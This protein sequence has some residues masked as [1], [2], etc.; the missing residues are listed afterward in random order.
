MSIKR[1]ASLFFRSYSDNLP[2]MLITE[3][4]IAILPGVSHLI[5]VSNPNY[6]KTKS[7]KKLDQVSASDS[8]PVLTRREREEIEA[9]RLAEEAEAAL[10]KQEMETLAVV[11]QVRQFVRRSKDQADADKIIS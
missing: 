9:Q 5:A 1:H 3:S 10:I 4:Q 6:V 7:A 2:A 11:R 8:R